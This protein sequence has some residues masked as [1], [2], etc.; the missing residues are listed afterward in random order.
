MGFSI[1]SWRGPN[2]CRA[3][4]GG[5]SGGRTPARRKSARAVDH[6]W[7]RRT[8]W[9]SATR[10]VEHIEPRVRR[11]VGQSAAIW[12]VRRG[13]VKIFAGRR[14]NGP[15]HPRG[16]VAFCAIARPE[17]FLP[18]CFAARGGTRWFIPR[19]F[20]DHHRYIRRTD[21]RRLTE[22]RCRSLGGRRFHHHG[23][24]CGEAHKGV[25][26][27]A[28]AD[29]ACC[30][31]GTPADRVC[32]TQTRGAARVWRHGSREEML[33]VRIGAMGD[34]LHAMPAVAAAAAEPAHPG[35]GFIRWADRAAVEATC[36][37]SWAT[38]TIFRWA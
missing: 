7:N 12:S 18:D 14:K 33:I 2:G 38:R 5:G 28:G 26:C 36:C 17:G 8:R 13:R 10:S 35:T 3:G 34:V 19:R 31:R 27:A 37:R 1:A 23:E 24:R 25:A 30:W 16:L 20:P 9:W 22:R 32:R 15:M 4:D 6:R 29:S 11:L 21:M